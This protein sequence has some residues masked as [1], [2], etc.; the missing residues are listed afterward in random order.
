M[1]DGLSFTLQ[2]AILRHAGQATS[3][4]NNYNSLSAAQKNQLIVFLNSL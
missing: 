2:E 4:T 3:V 1:H